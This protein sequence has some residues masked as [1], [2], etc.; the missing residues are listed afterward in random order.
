MTTPEP[1]STNLEASLPDLLDPAVRARLAAALPA[2]IRMLEA[3]GLTR[4][5]QEGLLTLSPR[6][7]RRAVQ[8]ESPPHL[9]QDQLMRMSLITGIYSA[10][11]VLY[12]ALTADTWMTRPNRRPPF[13]GHGPIRLI[14]NGG[15][16]ALLT[17]R[18][19]LDADR[20]GQFGGSQVARLT[21]QSLPQPE[22]DLTGP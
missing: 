17:V 6:T 12:D 20:S 19:I 11:H 7:I 8:G 16:P 14:L 9:N 15:I 2:V 18:R 10:L 1:D 4:G 3:W 22:I 13:G 5:E 21:A